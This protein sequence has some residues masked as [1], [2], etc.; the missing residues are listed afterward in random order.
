MNRVC[1]ALLPSLKK[2]GVEG[3]ETTPAPSLFHQIGGALT[4][5]A[6]ASSET[7]CDE[8]CDCE[9]HSPFLLA[10]KR[11]VKR[12]RVCLH[13]VT[14]QPRHGSCGLYKVSKT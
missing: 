4:H 13:Y 9:Q 5:E 2:S 14:G 12:I 6:E 8:E 3:A 10:E 1:A 7:E 11:G